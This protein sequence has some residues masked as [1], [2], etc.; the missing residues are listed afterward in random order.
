MILLPILPLHAFDDNVSVDETCHSIVKL[1]PPFANPLDKEVTIVGTFKGIVLLVLKDYRYTSMVLYN[2]F[3]GLTRLVPT[4]PLPPPRSLYDVD[5]LNFVYG[6]GYGADP[7]DLKIIKFSTWSNTCD[8][9]SL[10]MSSWSRSQYY[11]VYDVL[12]E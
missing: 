7:N 8:V 9:F 3:T 6:F 1:S 4:P 5:I 10:K 11:Y 12:L 2:P